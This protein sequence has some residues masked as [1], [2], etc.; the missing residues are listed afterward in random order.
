MIQILAATIGI[1]IAVLTDW[2]YRKIPNWLTFSLIIIG[3]TLNTLEGNLAGLEKSLLGFSVG[4]LLLFLPFQ[5]GGV[6][7]GDVKLMGAL[8][9]FLG[10]LLIFKVFL[11][12]AIFGGLFSLV[13][14]IKRKKLGQICSH[15]KAK[16]L[17]LLITKKVLLESDVTRERLFI[18]YSFAIGCGFLFILLVVQGG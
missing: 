14:A 3:L 16:I 6:G 10:P 8:G 2:R 18:P 1:G 12:S 5:C 11:A 17:Y 7:G 9:S 4:F 15:I 13:F